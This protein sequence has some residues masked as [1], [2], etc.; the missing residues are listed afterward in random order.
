MQNR[1]ILQ[2]EAGRCA[3]TEAERCRVGRQEG[4]EGRNGEGHKR[5]WCKA[6]RKW[7][8]RTKGKGEKLKGRGRS[9]KGT[10]KYGMSRKRRRNGVRKGKGM[11]GLEKGK[12]LGNRG[13]KRKGKLWT[14]R[15]GVEFI[16]GKG[17]NQAN[18][19]GRV[20]RG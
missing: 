5:D 11:R 8:M 3:V 13:R 10:Y 20:V 14:G 4:K 17:I 1:Y 9:W 6:R 19:Y 2:R 16:E 12:C 7:G 15:A 18:R